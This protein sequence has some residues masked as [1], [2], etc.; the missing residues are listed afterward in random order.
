MSA[1]L[2]LL[3]KA[4]CASIADEWAANA[5]G[6]RYKRSGD[7]LRAVILHP[8]PPH[9]KS[10]GVFW[11]MVLAT[12]CSVVKVVMNIFGV[13]AEESRGGQ[14]YHLIYSNFG[15]GHVWRIDNKNEVIRRDGILGRY[16]KGAWPERI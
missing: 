5:N 14:A 8:H 7:L 1:G 11:I 4:E 2:V 6:C 10:S 12:I 15:R 9:L 3:N 16:W 13:S